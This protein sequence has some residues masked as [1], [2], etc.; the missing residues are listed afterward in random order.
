MNGIPLI[1]LKNLSQ[2][3]T[4]RKTMADQLRQAFITA[5][6]AAVVNHNITQDAV[7]KIWK[8]MDSFFALPND[9]KEKY[10]VSITDRL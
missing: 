8:K 9:V 7:E 2:D 4:D 1:N 10:L 5:G 3:E 6:F